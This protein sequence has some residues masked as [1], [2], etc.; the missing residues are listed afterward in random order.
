M[1]APTFTPAAFSDLKRSLSDG[2]ESVTAAGCVAETGMHEA[3]RD[4]AETS[5]APQPSWLGC[6]DE[7]P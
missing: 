1:D 2:D 3:G 6:N 5:R 7:P 4:A